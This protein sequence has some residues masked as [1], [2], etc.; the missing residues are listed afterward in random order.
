MLPETCQF[1]Q[2]KLRTTCSEMSSTSRSDLTLKMTQHI[3]YLNY[4]ATSP[5]ICKKSEKSI[6]HYAMQTTFQST[7]KPY[8]WPAHHTSG[9]PPV[10]PLQPLDHED[11]GREPLTSNRFLGP[12]FRALLALFNTTCS[13]SNGFELGV[14]VK[15]LFCEEGS[16]VPVLPAQYQVI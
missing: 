14:Q 5:N 4:T 3:E 7:P 15:L 13:S 12:I 1:T 11:W 16:G 9:P 10:V 2:N 8:P 6:K